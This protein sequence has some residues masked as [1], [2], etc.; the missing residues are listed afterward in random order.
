[1]PVCDDPAH[2]FTLEASGT[3]RFTKTDEWKVR[4]ES[5]WLEQLEILKDSCT[6]YTGAYWDRVQVAW[7]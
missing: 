5:V 4:G 2:L 7:G 3:L 1:M 6:R